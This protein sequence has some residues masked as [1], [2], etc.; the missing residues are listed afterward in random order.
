ME[1]N[2]ISLR[3]NDRRLL[4][5]FPAHN[6][7]KVGRLQP[8]VKWLEHENRLSAMSMSGCHDISS[9]TSGWSTSRFASCLGPTGPSTPIGSRLIRPPRNEALLQ[10]GEMNSC[11]TA[12]DHVRPRA[13]T[14][15]TRARRDR[16]LQARQGQNKLGTKLLKPII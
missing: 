4:T 13:T 12:C 8:H 7:H 10:A 3:P 9:S 15:D 5:K 2:L 11:A 6:N 14:C 1:T 16:L